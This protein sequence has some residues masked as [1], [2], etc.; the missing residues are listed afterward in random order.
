[1]PLNPRGQIRN[2]DEWPP[3]RGPASRASVFSASRISEFMIALTCRKGGVRVL[4]GRTCEAPPRAHFVYCRN[5]GISP[6]IASSFDY[7]VAK[8]SVFDCIES[9]AETAAVKSANAP[10][11]HRYP[12]SRRSARP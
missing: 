12:L 1:M 6:R 2:C 10:S 9:A 3:E 5:T 4:T 7:W 8:S 11:L